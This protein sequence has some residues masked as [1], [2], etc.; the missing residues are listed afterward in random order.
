MN[1]RTASRYEFGDRVPLPGVGPGTTLLIA[2]STDGG[3]GRAL[4][5]DLVLPGNDR[6]EG[7]AVVSTNRDG[8]S[9]LD[10]CE[11]RYG[12]LDRARLGIIDATGQRGDVNRFSGDG[13][14][15]P[16]DLTGIGIAIARS[17]ESFAAEDVSR[18]RLGLDSV[19]TLL[20]Y[21]DAR[22][23]FRFVHTVGGRIATMGG[24]GAFLLDPTAQDER[25]NSTIEQ[26]CDGRL[27]VRED[28]DGAFEL[29]LR[30]LPDQ[31]TGWTPYLD[32]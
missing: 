13:I 30:G 3:A 1:Q 26:L 25:V 28:E 7:M 12:D 18:V 22:T 19:S 14:S 11:Q 6:D 27:D 15:N 29:R 23:V 10:E 24:F 21:A 31:P 4:L 9:L 20:L 5:L 32:G 16:G 17:F 8:Q 2:D